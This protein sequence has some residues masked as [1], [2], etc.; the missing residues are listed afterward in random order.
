MAQSLSSHS[1]GIHGLRFNHIGLSVANM[2]AQSQF[3]RQVLGFC[4]VVHNFTIQA[5]QSFQVVQ[6]QNPQGV[7]IELVQ[8]AD[9]VRVQTPTDPMDGSRIQGYFHWAL[10]VGDLDGIFEYITQ[11]GTG[12]RGISPP[13]ADESGGNGRYAYVVDPEGNLIELLSTQVD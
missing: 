3:Y 5:P 7:V 13:A 6:L 8:N 2:T 9:S 12:S 10:M 11:N 4:T 1:L